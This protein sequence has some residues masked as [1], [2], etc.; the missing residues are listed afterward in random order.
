M[1]RLGSGYKDADEVK[2][3]KF[4]EGVNWS[5]VLSRSA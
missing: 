2:Q 3:H 1:N 4:F 5:S